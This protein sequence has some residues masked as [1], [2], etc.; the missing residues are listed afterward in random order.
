M[1]KLPKVFLLLLILACT[2]ENNTPDSEPILSNETEIKITK[3][4][5]QEPNGWTY[6]VFLHIP[7]SE[8][9]V[10]GFPVLIL[11]HGNGGDGK[12]I[13]QEFR[14]L[15]SC[16]ILVSISGYRKSWNINDEESDAPDLEMIEDLTN[17]LKTFK[18]VNSDKIRILGYSNGSALANRIFVENKDESID[19][20]VGIVSQLSN[21][22]YR[23]GKFFKPSGTTGSSFP[24]N[25]YDSETIP[26]KNRSYLNI[27]NENDPV[28]PYFGGEFYGINFM[29]AQDAI[30]AIALSQGLNMNESPATPRIIANGTLEEFAYLN[31]QVVHLKGQAEHGIPEMANQYIVD[32]LADCD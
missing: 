30:F 19:L 15:L 2:K 5:S 8:P 32:F 29:N 23:N 14:N 25:G 11:L 1:M 22:Q 3:A 7:T 27:C 21:A 10:T 24:N 17:Q 26:L 16:H 13:I 31:Q 6:P 28:V 12:G 9:P 4:W 18:N 20:V